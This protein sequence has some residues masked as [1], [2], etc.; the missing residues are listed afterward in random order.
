MIFYTKQDLI[1][2]KKNVFLLR[3]VSWNDWWIWETEYNLYYYN[4]LGKEIGIGSVK[5][6]AVEE[7]LIKN[8]I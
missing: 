2:E 6:G 5:I 1:P 8:K 3:Q 7:K 4:E